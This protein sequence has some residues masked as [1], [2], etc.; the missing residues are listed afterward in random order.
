MKLLFIATL[1][2]FSTSVY[3]DDFSTNVTAIVKDRLG[4]SPTQEK[5][6]KTPQAVDCSGVIDARKGI[7]V[8]TSAEDRSVVKGMIEGTDFS[9]KTVNNKFILEKSNL[10]IKLAK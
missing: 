6:T 1:I 10:S 9:G 3:A 5:C 2:A 8:T 4:N 7:D